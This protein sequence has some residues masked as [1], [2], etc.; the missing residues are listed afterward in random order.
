MAKKDEAVR[1]DATKV[2]FEN[3]IPY[4]V[5]QYRSDSEISG[6]VRR[7]TFDDFDEPSRVFVTRVASVENDLVVVVSPITNTV[8]ELLVAASVG[9]ATAVLLENNEAE[10]A[11]GFVAEAISPLGT[12]NKMPVLI[13][14]AALDFQ[15]IYIS[16]G[17]PG[18]ALELSPSDLIALTNARTAPVTRD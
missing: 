7:M 16:S 18:F 9:S 6:G 10:S 2:L 12:R 5:H 17:A 8:D 4:A 1:T 13:D 3:N 14:L 11:T 15:T